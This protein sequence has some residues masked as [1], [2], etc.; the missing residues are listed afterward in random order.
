MLAIVPVSVSFA[1]ER[2]TESRKFLEVRGVEDYLNLMMAI[3]CPMIIYGQLVF[4]YVTEERSELPWYF[5]LKQRNEVE[6]EIDWPLL[7][8]VFRLGKEH[9][10][11]FIVDQGRL[12]LDQFGE[13]ARDYLK[14]TNAIIEQLDECIICPT[15]Q[16]VCN[17]ENLVHNSVLQPLSMGGLVG[18][19]P[20]VLKACDASMSSKVQR[21]MREVTLPWCLGASILVPLQWLCRDTGQLDPDV[22]CYQQVY[23]AGLMTQV[24]ASR[25]VIAK[26][27]GALEILVKLFQ[28][29]TH[30]ATQTTL[31]VLVKIPTPDEWLWIR[32]NMELLSTDKLI[33]GTY[34]L[35]ELFFFLYEVDP[36]DTWVLSQENFAMELEIALD[37][38]RRMHDMIDRIKMVEETEFWMQLKTVGMYPSRGLLFAD[39]DE[40]GFIAIPSGGKLRTHEFNVVMKPMPVFSVEDHDVHPWE[41]RVFF[42]QRPVIDQYWLG[43]VSNNSTAASTPVIAAAIG[44]ASGSAADLSTPPAAP[45]V[46]TGVGASHKAWVFEA[47][48][49]PVKTKF[50]C[51]PAKDFAPAAAAPPVVTGVGSSY[52]APFIGASNIPDNKKFIC[53]PAKPYTSAAAASPIGT[54]Y[55]AALRAAVIA[56]SKAAVTTKVTSP[57]TAASAPAVAPAVN[58]PGTPLVAA[59]VTAPSQPFMVDSQRISNGNSEMI[60]VAHPELQ[61]DEQFPRSRPQKPRSWWKR[62]LSRFACCTHGAKKPASQ[63]LA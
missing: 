23:K 34:K 46:V 39:R 48:N 8:K 9:F 27:N 41:N 55:G 31:Y 47:S 22:F 36:R 37:K 43:D 50:T 57:P 21:L 25:R 15:A 52:N 6:F 19:N 24:S 16:D 49:I 44:L 54:G 10:R 53:G 61:T 7:L 1:S 56:A 38:Q 26:V 45:P 28:V 3:V 40:D 29:S 12:R 5:C 11:S 59:T 62:A 13:V 58:A 51:P 14:K 18:F 17:L 30:Q 63:R 2:E 60:G 42:N 35:N 4:Q 32:E 20:E 33:G